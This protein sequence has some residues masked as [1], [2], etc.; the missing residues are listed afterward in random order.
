[1]NDVAPGLRRYI[2][3]NIER[4]FQDRVRDVIQQEYATAVKRFEQPDF[5]K[6]SWLSAEEYIETYTHYAFE[7]YPFLSPTM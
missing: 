4:P 5:A 3:R 2:Q 6:H 7:Y 1:M